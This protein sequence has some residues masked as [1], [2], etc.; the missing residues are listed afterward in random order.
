[1]RTNKMHDEACRKSLKYLFGEEYIKSQNCH[2]QS[3]YR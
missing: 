1:M 2:I 3:K